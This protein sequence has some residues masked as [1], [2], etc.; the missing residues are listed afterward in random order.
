MTEMTEYD[1]KLAQLQD[2]YDAVAADLTAKGYQP[3][4]CPSKGEGGWSPVVGVTGGA[5]FPTVL[6]RP[7]GE[8]TRLAIRPPATVILID[9]DHYAHKTGYHTIERAEEAISELPQTWRLTSRGV[10]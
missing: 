1:A 4:W 2:V 9:V 5:P 3:V 10:G 6:P 8:P 7:Q